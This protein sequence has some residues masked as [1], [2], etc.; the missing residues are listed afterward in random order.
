[1]DKKYDVVSFI[2]YVT[3]IFVSLLLYEQNKPLQEVLLLEKN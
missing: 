2:K 3:V 1:M